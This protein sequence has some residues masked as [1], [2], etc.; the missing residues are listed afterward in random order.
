VPTM[1]IV[2]CLDVASLLS[3]ETHGFF[4]RLLFIIS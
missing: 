3:A 4:S 1:G 2:H